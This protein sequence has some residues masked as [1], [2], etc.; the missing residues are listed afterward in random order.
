MKRFE[1][2]AY[3]N[4]L[5]NDCLAD[6]DVVLA[7]KFHNEFMKVAQINQE[8]AK[9]ANGPE[10]QKATL[11]LQAILGVGQDGLFGP[12]TAYAL[13]K[14]LDGISPEPTLDK[15]YVQRAREFVQSLPVGFVNVLKNFVGMKDAIRELEKVPATRPTEIEPSGVKIRL[16]QA[17]AGY[18]G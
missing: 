12:S 1:K 3:L 18:R 16:L 10:M 4:T 5:A 8:E 9:K 11:S 13:V 7:S 6:N 15:S 17:L 2:L 14:A